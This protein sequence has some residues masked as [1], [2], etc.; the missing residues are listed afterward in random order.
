MERE[1]SVIEVVSSPQSKSLNLEADSEIAGATPDTVVHGVANS[2][3]PPDEMPEMKPRGFFVG[4]R[5]IPYPPPDCVPI[6]GLKVAPL[7][8]YI[9]C[10]ST[11]FSVINV[12][13]VI[14]LALTAAI[15]VV[16]PI[17]QV[18]MHDTALPYRIGLPG[19]L[20][21][22]AF[23]GSLFL[24]RKT[25]HFDRAARVLLI[26]EH[27]L[28]CCCGNRQE[29]PFRVLKGAQPHS[30][31]GRRTTIEIVVDLKNWREV[32]RMDGS[33]DAVPV[34]NPASHDEARPN[35][36]GE[37]E[38]V[39][40]IAEVENAPDVIRTWRRYIDWLRDDAF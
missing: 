5:H 39:I 17:L 37:D 34:E 2:A 33:L 7:P 13:M 25:V 18:F 28:Y 6:N 16:L 19:G 35:D 20:A 4:R 31:L 8:G 3:T 30:G 14:V 9:D 15:L 32:D 12:A 22:V 1:R 29:I 10:T 26:A 11:S 21:L 24:E 38:L 27:R 36:D 23:I 40:S